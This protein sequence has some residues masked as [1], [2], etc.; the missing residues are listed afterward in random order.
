M[1][2][3]I[4]GASFVSGPSL[5]L[6]GTLSTPEI[7]ACEPSYF[8]I[9]PLYLKSKLGYRYYLIKKNSI[10][11]LSYHLLLLFCSFILNL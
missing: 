10:L 2:Q 3:K 4:G 1:Q 9:T 8:K 5:G 7:R 11:C 6:L